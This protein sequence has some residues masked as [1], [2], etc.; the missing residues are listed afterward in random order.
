MNVPDFQGGSW[1]AE[2]CYWTG[3]GFV[4]YCV[5][6]FFLDRV[7]CRTGMCKKTKFGRCKREWRREV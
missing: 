3:L 6:M 7:A 2:I 1:F 4:V 5:V